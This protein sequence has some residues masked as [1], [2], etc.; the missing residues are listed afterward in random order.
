MPKILITG[1]GFDLNI[2]LPT[3]YND[4]INILSHIEVSQDLNFNDIYQKTSNFDI[5]Q[6]N[7]DRFKIDKENLAKLITQLKHNLWFQFF[8]SEFQIETWIDFENKIE[9]VLENI[10][11]SIEYM[12]TNLFNGSGLR[13][14]NITQSIDIFKSNIEI[15]QVLKSFTIIK[16]RPNITYFDLN[17]DFLIKKYGKFINVDVEKLTKFLYQQLIEFKLIFN[18]Y[19]EIF[20]TPLSENIKLKIDR[21][22]FKNIDYHYTFNFTSTFENLYSR[23]I[24]KY[25]H[26]KINSKNN[27]I[28]LGINEVPNNTRYN[29]EFISFTKYFQKL[30]NDTDYVFL[31]ELEINSYENYIFFF[32]GHSLDRSDRDYI[33]E[34]F[35]FIDESQSQMKKIV[36]AYHNNT[37]KSKMLINLLDIRGSKNIQDLMRAKNLIFVPVN[38]DELRLE[39]DNDIRRNIY[40]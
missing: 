16:F 4:F 39:L 34:V 9:Y 40:I 38:S 36:I 27:Q 29:R 30:N 21:S 12:E 32:W 14:A 13:E 22:Y 37:S 24:T 18:Y 10:F 8:K 15:T 26:G 35:D 17:I 19:F 3:S 7:Y 28:V 6:K 31:R 23:N 11:S 2:G 33:N 20:I 25:L 5:I 1:N